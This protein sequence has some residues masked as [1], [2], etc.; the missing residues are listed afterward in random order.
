MSIASWLQ[1][2]RI[3]VERGELWR[4]MTGHWV[5]WGWS[6]C[7]WSGGAFVLLAVL[8]GREA[9]RRTLGCVIVAS[10]AIGGAF[11]FGTDLRFYRGLSG[12]DSALFTMLEVEMLSQQWRER[13]W[14]WVGTA[15]SALLLGFVGK[16]GYEVA[17]G[18][19]LFVDIQASGM[20]PVPLA[21]A[22]GAVVGVVMAGLRG[23]V[24]AIAE[25]L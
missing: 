8:S 21:H 14:D 24:G 19:A 16:L 18:Q 23:S 10:L 13:R 2:D 25:C 5:H 20:V 15:A 11:W 9:F 1:F 6:H 22:V 3:A 7:F 17:T 12:I 4:L